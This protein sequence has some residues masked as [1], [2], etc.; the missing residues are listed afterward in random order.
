MASC[1]SFIVELVELGAT[2]LYNLGTSVCYA[3]SDLFM[4]LLQLSGRSLP[5]QL[6]SQET[7]R[8]MAEIYNRMNTKVEQFL[9]KM[10]N[11]TDVID[12]LI[13]NGA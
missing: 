3:K 2:G 4:K 13:K 11:L 9:G 8:N 1:A 10:P 5:F 7:T 12:N 6:T